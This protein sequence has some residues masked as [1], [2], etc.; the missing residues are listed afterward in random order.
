VTAGEGDFGLNRGLALG[1]Y[2]PFH[3]GHQSVIETSLREMDETI[4]LVYDSPEVTPIP[5]S[6]R[7]G[8]IRS[9][10]PQA[11]VMEVRGGP[12]EVG[13]TPEIMRGHEDFI[14][15]TLAIRGVT[16]FYSS[17]QYGEHLSKA[18]GA[19]DRRVDEARVLVPVSATD[20]RANPFALRHYLDPLVYRDLVTHAVFIGAPSTG[21]T[22]LAARLA[23]VFH[24]Q[25]M[26]EYGREYW[27]EHQVERRL[28][29]DELIEIAEGHL[30]REEALLLEADHYLFTDTNALTTA[31]FAR[32]YHGFIPRRLAELADQAEH[33]YDLV[34]LC[35]T[36]IPYDDTWDRSGD[37]NR[38]EFQ[39]MIVA[40]LFE[41]GIPFV[42]VRG[43]LEERLQQVAAVLQ[44]FSKYGSA[45]AGVTE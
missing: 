25:W 11:V 31:V 37:A 6:V 32:Y 14:L 19:V 42:T 2:A 30:Q 33:R 1:K 16:H 4:V 21:K 7:A 17:E 23:Q 13:Y 39:A 10:Y 27:E 22:T 18:L 20:I 15:D 43:A 12:S 40:D 38:T 29:P 3:R 34:F 45:K 8:W 44:G 26:P 41:R 5:L 28:T 36:D 24:T 9:L 35:D